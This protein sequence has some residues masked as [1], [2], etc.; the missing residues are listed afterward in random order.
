MKSAWKRGGLAIL[1]AGLVVCLATG[2]WAAEQSTY[3]SESAAPRAIQPILDEGGFNT[4][5]QQEPAPPAP[6]DLGKSI[7]AG[8]AVA[9]PTAPKAAQPACAACEG[10]CGACESCDSCGIGRR[11][12][13]NDDCGDDCGPTWTVD[14]GAIVLHR[15]GV[16][17]FIIDNAP[18]GGPL[19]T[20]DVDDLGWAT[21]PRIDLVRH[22]G[23]WDVHPAEHGG[24]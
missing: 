11:K 24:G 6:P 21:G 15:S 17:D 5:D 14:A 2:A 8:K 16:R 4:A 19:R 10:A 3:R 18:R 23:C 13:L 12:W 9:A 20:G 1:Q 22:S 7:R